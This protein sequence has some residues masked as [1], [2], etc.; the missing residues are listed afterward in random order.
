[1]AT[2]ICNQNV[3]IK[4]TGHYWRPH[5]YHIIIFQVS[6]SS[7]LLSNTLRPH[8]NWSAHSRRD[9]TTN[10]DEDY[11][12][13]HSL[14]FPIPRTNHRNCQIRKYEGTVR[15]TTPVALDTKYVYKAQ[16]IRYYL[17]LFTI[18]MFLQS[19]NHSLLT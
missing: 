12:S 15:V 11:L 10:T 16:Y 9:A 6:K 13:V 18:D 7:V 8:K 3:Q 2:R 1:M 17:V 4:R 5:H 19:R 14:W